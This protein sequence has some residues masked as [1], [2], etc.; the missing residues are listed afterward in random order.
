MAHLWTMR[1]NGPVEF[2]AR[3]TL[4][5]RRVPCLRWLGCIVFV[6]T[7]LETFSCLSQHPEISPLGELRPF[8]HHQAILRPGQY[9]EATGHQYVLATLGED[10]LEKIDD[11]GIV[12]DRR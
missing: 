7:V 6:F 9:R 2:K 1:S 12:H 8:N 10:I 5:P 4:R 11:M 3:S